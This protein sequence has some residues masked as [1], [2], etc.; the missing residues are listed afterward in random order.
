VGKGGREATP[1]TNYNSRN[2][3]EAK[4]AKTCHI[5]LP[6]YILPTPLSDENWDIF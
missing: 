6:K 5:V 1:F 3:K 2:S 4:N